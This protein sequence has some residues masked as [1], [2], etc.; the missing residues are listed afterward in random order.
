MGDWH[1]INLRKKKLDLPELNNG[2]LFAE[3]NSDLKAFYKF[4]GCVN[5]DGYIEYQSGRWKKT[6]DTKS[7]F[8]W[9]ELPG[10]PD[11]L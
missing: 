3:Y 4:V 10:D 7:K 8:Y 11:I 5:K 2:V 9:R 6:S 1:H